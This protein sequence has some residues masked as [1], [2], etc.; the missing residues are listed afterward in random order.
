MVAYLLPVVGI[1]L[2]VL[3]RHEAVT[4]LTVLGAGM[5]I[6]GVAL[7]NSRYGHRRLIGRSAPPAVPG[8]A[9][10]SGPGSAARSGAAPQEASPAADRAP[11]PR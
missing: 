3:V 5:V 4:L 9:S 11:A 6:G 1:V 10:T 2:G 7:A 8:A